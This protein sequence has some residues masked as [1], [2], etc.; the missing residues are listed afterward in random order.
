[1]WKGRKIIFRPLE[2]RDAATLQKWYVD[3]DFRLGY[4]EYAS[5]DLE[6]IQQEIA[7]LGGNVQYPRVEKVVYMVQRKNDRRPI[8][9][10]GLR[11]IDRRNGNAE[12]ILGIGERICVWPV[13][14]WIF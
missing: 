11:N 14:V 1:M 10:A 13:M 5:V 8:G 12:I 6:T 4:N 9:L 3:K 7:T 2:F